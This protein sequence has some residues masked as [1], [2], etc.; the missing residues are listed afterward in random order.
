MAGRPKI[1][2]KKKP[3][4]ICLTDTLKAKLLEK[5]TKDNR[6]FSSYIEQILL[7]AIKK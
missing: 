2:D 7:K 6:S 4:T 3:V 5:A 1:Q